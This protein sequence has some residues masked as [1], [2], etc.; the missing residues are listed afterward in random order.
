VRHH[1]EQAGV[2][3]R[4]THLRLARKPARL[5]EYLCSNRLRYKVIRMSGHPD[6]PWNPAVPVLIRPREFEPQ[7]RDWPARSASGWRQSR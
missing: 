3:H 2:Y 5:R 1:D 7:V 4:I 6:P